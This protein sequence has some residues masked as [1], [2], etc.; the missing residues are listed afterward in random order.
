MAETTIQHDFDHRF[1]AELIE[2]LLPALPLLEKLTAI[3]HGL[4]AGK[5]TAAKSSLYSAFTQNQ[6]VKEVC[7]V[8]NELLQGAA[9]VESKPEKLFDPYSG[10]LKAIEKHRRADVFEQFERYKDKFR[11]KAWQTIVLYYQGELSE[12]QISQIFRRVF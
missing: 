5:K 3:G 11:A 9:G 10:S 2:A 7:K 4:Q 12:E 6:T 1:G 8:L